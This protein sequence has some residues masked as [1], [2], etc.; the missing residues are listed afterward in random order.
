MTLRRFTDH[1]WRRESVNLAAHLRGGEGPVTYRSLPTWSAEER[2]SSQEHQLTWD[3]W[4]ET[5]VSSLT[6]PGGHP[7]HTVSYWAKT[8]WELPNGRP[9]LKTSVYWSTL[10]SRPSTQPHPQAFLP[11]KQAECE[12]NQALRSDCQLTG[13]SDRQWTTR[14]L[15]APKQPWE[16]RGRATAEEREDTSTGRHARRGQ[17]SCGQTWA[18]RLGRTSLR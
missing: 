18:H 14:H 7:R 8:A 17:A 5:T 6:Q 16:R 9:R 4:S 2:R 13:H 12:R 15:F 3:G 11:N 1:Q 10:E